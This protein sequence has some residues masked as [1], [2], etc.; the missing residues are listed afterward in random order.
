MYLVASL[1][2]LAVILK[3]IIQLMNIQ[4]CNVKLMLQ[5]EERESYV[6]TTFQLD[7]VK[8]LNEKTTPLRTEGVRIQNNS[9]PKLLN[10]KKPGTDHPF[11]LIND[12]TIDKFRL[13]Q[14]NKSETLRNHTAANRRVELCRREGGTERKTPGRYFSLVFL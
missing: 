13:T 14:S 7:D 12:I 3:L 8:K 1:V 11:I 10:Y 2:L 9:L 6:D 4:S 5:P